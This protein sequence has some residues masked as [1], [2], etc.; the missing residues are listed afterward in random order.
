MRRLATVAQSSVSFLGLFCRLLRLL[1]IDD[2]SRHCVTR[3]RQVST[4]H[5][6]FFPCVP[7]SVTLRL[8]SVA[9]V[10]KVGALSCTRLEKLI[11]LS[12]NLL[13][14][15]TARKGL[16]RLFLNLQFSP[17][18]MSWERRCTYVYACM[19]CYGILALLD[20]VSVLS[21]KIG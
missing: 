7:T 20:Y 12:P 18:S 16:V 8:I 11:E 21:V 19:L 4:F 5:T 10:Q 1:Y 13:A 15:V 17:N 14:D 6:Y 9:F 3:V 2:Q